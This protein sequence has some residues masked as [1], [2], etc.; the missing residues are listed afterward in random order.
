MDAGRGEGGGEAPAE[1]AAE[2]LADVVHGDD[3]GAG[4][5]EELVEAAEVVLGD[6][7]GEGVSRGGGREG[8]AAA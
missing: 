8:G 7:E 2:A 1:P 6:A 3:V 5:E 4:A